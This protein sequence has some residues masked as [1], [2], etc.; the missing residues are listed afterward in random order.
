MLVRHVVGH[1]S[2]QPPWFG[3]EGHVAVCAVPLCFRLSLHR[4]PLFLL[5]PV[6]HSDQILHRGQG[7]RSTIAV[8]VVTPRC[9]RYWSKSFTLSHKV[10]HII[11]DVKEAS[12]GTY[13]ALELYVKGLGQDG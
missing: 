5:K 12:C 3:V 11:G 10:I 8:L 4:R 9:E 2:L 13:G 7:C 6:F 1:S